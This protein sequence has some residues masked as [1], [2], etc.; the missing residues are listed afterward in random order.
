MFISSTLALLWV[1]PK[2]VYIYNHTIKTKSGAVFNFLETFTLSSCRLAINTLDL[3]AFDNSIVTL[4]FKMNL[5]NKWGMVAQ[6]KQ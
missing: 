6:E 4:I 1:N 2:H 3:C 5:C